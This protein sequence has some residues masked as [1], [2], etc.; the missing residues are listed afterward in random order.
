MRG[1]RWD[2]RL[3]HYWGLSKTEEKLQKLLAE[4]NFTPIKAALYSNFV[5]GG[6]LGIYLS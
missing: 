4:F 6:E 1:L 2:Y 3:R 5:G